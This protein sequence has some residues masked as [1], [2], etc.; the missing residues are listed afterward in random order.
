[1]L[2]RFWLIRHAETAAPDIFH[3]AESDIGLSEHGRRTSHLVAPYLAAFRPDAVISSGMR[4]AVDTATPIAAAC[5]VTL[6]IEPLLHERRIG[7]LSGVAC[8]ADNPIRLEL[9][10]RWMAG[11]TSY[12]TAGAESFED[13]RARAVPVLERLAAEFD[14]RSA[15]VVAHG[16]TI[17]I[18]LLSI[19]PG[20]SPADWRRFGLINN[21]A[22]TELVGSDGEWRAETLPKVPDGVL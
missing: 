6:R 21:L 8:D 9:M 19:L 10:R 11:D 15:V 3:G 13:V 1:M 2:A 5:G 4:R 22:V 16:A 14:G 17:K 18:V 12:S 7:E 20:W